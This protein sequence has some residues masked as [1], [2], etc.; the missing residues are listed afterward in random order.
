LS[1]RDGRQKKKV[2]PREDRDRNRVW[3]TYFAR[4]PANH[5]YLDSYRPHDLY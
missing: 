2:N 4:R 5:P 1:A 3:D